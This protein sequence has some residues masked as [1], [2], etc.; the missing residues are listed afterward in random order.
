M[1]DVRKQ[2][3][4]GLITAINAKSTGLTVYTKIPK[5]DALNPISYPF[6]YISEIYDYEDGPKNQ[7]MYQYEVVLEVVYKDLNSKIAMWTTV[8]KIKQTINNNSPFTLTDNFKIMESTLI[9]TEETETL[10][11]S[12]EVSTTIIRMNFQ[13]EDNN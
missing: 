12:Q 5:G 3:S 13:I 8:D 10:I 11:N 2:L 9:S 7:F 4:I 1:K 6:I